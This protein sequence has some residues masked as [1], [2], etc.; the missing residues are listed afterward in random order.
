MYLFLPVSLKLFLDLFDQIYLIQVTT[1][2]QIESPIMVEEEQH[3]RDVSSPINTTDGK[4][5]ALQSDNDI[6]PATRYPPGY[7]FIPTDQELVGHYLR[8]KL[9]QEELPINMRNEIE[10]YKHNPEELAG[11]EFNPLYSLFIYLYP[12]HMYTSLLIYIYIY[13]CDCLRRYSVCN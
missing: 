13:L 1:E 9:A 3:K 8:K 5:N 6:D 10:L 7:R 12:L 4:Q 2:N 11:F